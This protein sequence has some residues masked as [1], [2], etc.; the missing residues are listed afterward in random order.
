LISINPFEAAHAQSA[1]RKAG[2]LMQLRP[3]G[4]TDGAEREARGHATNGRPARVFVG[5]KAVPE[6]AEKLVRIAQGLERFE[7][8]RVAADDIHL[9]LVPPW[10][11]TSIPDA[12]A[13]LGRVAQNFRAFQL[14]F[15]H[16]GYG[17]QPRRPRLLWADCASSDEIAALRMA[18]LQAYGQTDERPFKPHVTLARIRA[19]GPAI[20]RKHPIDQPLS[21]TQRVESIELFQSPA[22]GSSG[23]RVLAS[24]RLGEIADSAPKS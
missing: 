16:V 10:N 15:R 2:E 7:V 9:T 5:L 19:A 6:I 1:L 3:G 8:R 4:F 11:E 20:A 14:T 18:L 21:L 13:K 12:I 23:Y 22:P 17:P 24:L